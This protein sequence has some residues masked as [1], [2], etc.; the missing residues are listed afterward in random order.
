[1][2]VKKPVP[3]KSTHKPD[4]A[5]TPTRRELDTDELDGVV[6]GSLNR[7]SEPAPKKKKP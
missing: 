1:M 5:K 7:I 4:A 3:T 6:G 2:A